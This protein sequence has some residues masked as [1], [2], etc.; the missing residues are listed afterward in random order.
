MRDFAINKTCKIKTTLLFSER[1]DALELLIR[2]KYRQRKAANRI[3]GQLRSG[4]EIAP[5]DCA[6]F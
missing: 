4:A 6:V 1:S 5:P 3:L 2:S